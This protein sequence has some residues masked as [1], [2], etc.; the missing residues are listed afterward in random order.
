MAAAVE[1][2]ISEQQKA[3]E[4]E[5]MAGDELRSLIASI[6]KETWGTTSTGR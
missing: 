6:V 1:K 2:K 5:K 3:S 4:E